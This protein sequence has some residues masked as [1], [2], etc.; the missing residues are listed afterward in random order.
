MKNS[1]LLTV[2]IFHKIAS[3]L[4]GNQ[5][6]KNFALLRVSIHHSYY[7]IASLLCKNDKK[8]IQEII[9]VNDEAGFSTISHPKIGSELPYSGK[10]E[11]LTC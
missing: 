5:I 7:L 11:H 2:N 9:L 10:R 1:I 3:C 6:E 4:I 8:P